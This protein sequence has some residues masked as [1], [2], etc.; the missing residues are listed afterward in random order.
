MN[1]I[2]KLL[3]AGILGAGMVVSSGAFAGTM[4]IDTFDVKNDAGW[5][6]IQFAAPGSISLT[7]TGAALGGDRNTTINMIATGGSPDMLYADVIIADSKFSYN[8]FDGDV[9]NAIFTY[10]LSS[11]TGIIDALNID[12]LSTDH[13]LDIS[14]DIDGSGGSLAANAAG[15]FSFAMVGFDLATANLLTVTFDAPAALDFSI[16]NISFT[17]PAVAAPA[18]APLALMSLGLVALATVK[19]RKSA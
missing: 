7:D 19:R 12:V 5:P 13:G 18:P 4:M 9:G 17:T 1:N 3:G 2:R 16:D 8:A 11:V 14:Y 6:A 15:S 10:D